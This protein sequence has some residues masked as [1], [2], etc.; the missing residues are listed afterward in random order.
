MNKIQEIGAYLI[1]K[2]VSLFDT[3]TKRAKIL[4]LYPFY[5][6]IFIFLIFS[7][8]T[9]HVANVIKI[10]KEGDKTLE[11]HN[12]KFD[13][14][15]EKFHEV[16]KI[17]ISFLNFNMYAINTVSINSADVKGIDSLLN[18]VILDQSKYGIKNK[19]GAIVYNNLNVKDVGF[20]QVTFSLNVLGDYPNPIIRDPYFVLFFIPT[21]GS[22]IMSY[23]YCVTI[24]FA[25]INI[26]A[27]ITKF[28]IKGH[29]LIKM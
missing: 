18:I 6:I 29:P 23:I 25:L 11:K 10:N 19:H 14:Y 16:T 8:F 20:F 27:S 22:F 28:I 15:L 2:L 9:I 24:F 7:L 3:K 1:K 5:L 17:P 26:F 21:L 12:I 4:F 13:N